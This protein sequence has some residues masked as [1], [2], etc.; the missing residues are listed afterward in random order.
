MRGSRVAQHVG[1]GLAQHPPEGHLERGVDVAGIALRGDLDAG[2]PQRQLERPRLR[3]QVVGA[4]PPD[5]AAHLAEGLAQERAQLAEFGVGTRRIGVQDAVRELGLQ[6]DD[7]QRVAQPVVH[8][9]GHPLS[10]GDDGQVPCH[11]LVAVVGGHQ[12]RLG[13]VDDEHPRQDDQHEP[14]APRLAAGE[15]SG[16]AAG[17]GRAAHPPRTGARQQIAGVGDHERRH[18]RGGDA[19]QGGHGQDD[20][21]HGAQAHPVPVGEAEPAAH[22][23]AEDD[24]GREV[25]RG[26]KCDERQ[27]GGDPGGSEPGR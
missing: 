8:V 22:R 16:E 21:H 12:G 11:E 3:G 9:P 14:I 25:H 1:P 15:E 6:G 23:S 5:G 7:G 19:D 13:H 18:E 10:L 27:P 26:E 24:E 2:A 17:Q 4:Q 20:G